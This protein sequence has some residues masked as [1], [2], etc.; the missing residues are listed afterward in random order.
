MHLQES[1]RKQY[2][3]K[4][5]KSGKLS[6]LALAVSSIL[7]KL[8]TTFVD[9]NGIKLIV[10]KL[11]EA[12]KD[13]DLSTMRLAQLLEGLSEACPALFAT[14]LSELT[15]L[16]QEGDEELVAHVL[17]ILANVGNVIKEDSETARY[18]NLFSNF[19]RSTH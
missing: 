3:A 10:G 13:N 5:T 8:S 12:V 17:R 2:V 4:K 15:E 6:A 1:L 19:L 11:H 9:K 18:V 14:S 7:D 16:L